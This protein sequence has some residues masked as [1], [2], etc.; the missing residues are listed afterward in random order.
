LNT[1][2]LKVDKKTSLKLK[3]HPNTVGKII[4]PKKIANK[5]NIK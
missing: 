5:G 4:K 3:Y 1:G 2:L